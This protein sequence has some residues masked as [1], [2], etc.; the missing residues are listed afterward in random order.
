MRSPFTVSVSLQSHFS[1]CSLLCQILV[2]REEH[3]LDTVQLID[4]AGTRIVIDGHDIGTRIAVTQFHDFPCRPAWFGREK[5][6]RLRAKTMFG[7]PVWIGSNISPVKNQPSPVWLPSDTMSLAYLARSSMCA[8]AV[9]C[10]L[11]VNSS[12]AALRSHSKK[13]MPRR[14]IFLDF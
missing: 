13:L 5:G 1:R 3:Q 7:V 8:G 12:L 11:F 14:P 6:E 9:K 2:C 4:L 10:L